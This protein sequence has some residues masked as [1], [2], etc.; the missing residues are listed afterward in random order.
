MGMNEAAAAAGDFGAEDAAA[1][2]T[3]CFIAFALLG[4]RM[5][6]QLRLGH[7][8][9]HALQLRSSPGSAAPGLASQGSS[10]QGLGAPA[11]LPLVPHGVR[12]LRLPIIN[13]LHI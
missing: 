3:T 10:T 4:S 8:G 11:V 9:A 12:T 2:G 1:D 5:V 7:D 6:S 13:S